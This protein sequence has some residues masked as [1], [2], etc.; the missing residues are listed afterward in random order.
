LFFRL[1]VVT[2]RMPPLRDRLEDLS[3]LVYFFLDALGASDKAD[4]FTPEVMEEMRRYDWPGNVRE[5]R[6]HVERHVIFGGGAEAAGEVEQS[7]ERASSLPSAPQA[8]NLEMPFKQAKEAVVEAFEKRYLAALLEW[9][10]GNVSRAA[11]KANIDRVYLHRL[12][13]HY[14]LRPG[15]SLSD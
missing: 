10:E 3:M 9:A 12:L 7:M 2:L 5:L 15:S 4:H 14:G 11:R 13:R 6:N 8:V 1:S